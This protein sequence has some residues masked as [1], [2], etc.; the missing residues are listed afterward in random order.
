MG[1]G[2]SFSHEGSA[3]DMTI[4]QFI[5]Q[6]GVVKAADPSPFNPA[7]FNGGFGVAPGY[8]PQSGA[9]TGPT[10]ITGSARGSL[11][12]RH[13]QRGFCRLGEKC[14]F[15]HVGA[16]TDGS[17]VPPPSVGPGV[18]SDVVE[19]AKAKAEEAAKAISAALERKNAGTA[20]AAEAALED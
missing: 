10:I 15:A 6:G 1:D 7:T 2:C 20:E 9:P 14:G 12:C 13:F 3:G 4:E 11:P 17:G 18:S 19:L 16:P 5:S 8:A